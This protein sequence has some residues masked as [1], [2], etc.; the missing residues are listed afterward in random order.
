[1]GGGVARAYPVIELV[2]IA[3]VGKT[4]LLDLL[5]LR[6]GSFL[7]RPG[8]WRLPPPLL[9]RSAGPALP[10]CLALWRNARRVPWEETKHLIR[11]E[12]LFHLVRRARARR[13]VVLDEGPV[14]GLSWLRALGCAA[15]GPRGLGSWWRA[16]LSRWRDALDVIVLLDAPNAVLAQ[17]IRSREKTH[18]FKDRSDAE[19]ERFLDL[20]RAAL[21]ETL[22]DLAGGAGTRADVLRARTDDRPPQAIVD[23]LQHRLNG[24]LHAR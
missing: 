7:C 8:V 13:T 16:T 18:A 21:A 5:Q 20:S 14:F 11:L 3:G 19:L 4:T 2:G 9:L 1:M 23:D 6:D 10:W 15:A 17:R 12:A 22:A 24:R